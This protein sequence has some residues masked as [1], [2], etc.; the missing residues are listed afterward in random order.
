MPL[1]PSHAQLIQPSP[2]PKPKDDGTIEAELVPFTC[3]WAQNG[4]AKAMDGMVAVGSG[5]EGYGIGTRW[6]RYRTAAEHLATVD[7]WQKMVELYCG[8]PPLPTSVTGR[9]TASRVIL[10]DV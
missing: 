9:D 6:V 3:P 7:Y 5:T 8:T 4:L 10:R 2:P 1:P